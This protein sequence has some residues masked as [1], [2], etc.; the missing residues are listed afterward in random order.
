MNQLVSEPA[1]PEFLADY[2]RQSIRAGSK[3][4]AGASALFDP[5]LKQSVQMLYAWCR[6]C[7]D[8]IDDQVLGFAAQPDSIQPGPI[9]A[10][11]TR[12]QGRLAMLRDKTERALRGDVD[13]PAFAALALVANRHGI[14]GRFAFELLDGFE[15]DAIGRR[16]LSLDDTIRYSYHVA[17]VVGIMM[18]MVMGARDDPTLDR[19]CDL[20]IGFQLT[21]IC[22]DVMDDARIGR[23][24]VP[25]QWLGLPPECSAHQAAAWVLDTSNTPTVLQTVARLLD[26]AERYYD[27]AYQGLNRLPVRAACAIATARRIYRRIGREVRAGGEAALRE[28]VVVSRPRKLAGAVLGVVDAV[29]AHSLGR[30]HR[31][32]R[33]ADLWRRPGR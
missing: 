28:R 8:V 7:D 33:G 17:G 1:S 14:P 31:V 5:A 13:E 23:V 11:P 21:N 16:H 27:S 15:M 24:Y 20:G 10:D 30:L 29:T 12:V 25:E 6:H 26:Q 3:S 9:P 2:A 19:A 22:R 4:F 32:P 18:A